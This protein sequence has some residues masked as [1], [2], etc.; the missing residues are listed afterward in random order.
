MQPGQYR[1]SADR[2]RLR[3]AAD[4]VKQSLTCAKTRVGP[5][6]SGTRLS[7]WHRS[8]KRLGAWYARRTHRRHAGA[9]PAAERG[10]RVVSAAAGV[11]RGDGCGCSGEIGAKTP[12]VRGR[13]PDTLGKDARRQIGMARQSEAEIR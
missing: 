7:S 5:D 4:D 12:F 10:N 13:T 6:P 3:C 8:R 11:Q 2:V 1:S 9:W